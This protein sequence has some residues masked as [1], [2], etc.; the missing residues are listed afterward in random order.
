MDTLNTKFPNEMWMHVFSYSDGQSLK[1]VSL[2]SRRF[3]SLGMEELLH[4]LVW[5]SKKQAEQNLDF[6]EAAVDCRYI[7]TSLSMKFSRRIDP[8]PDIFNH[9]P[10][11]YNLGTLSLSDASCELP[12]PP[13]HFPL[14]Y[15]SFSDV[16][17]EPP[18]IGITDLSVRN[19]LGNFGEPLPIPE[20][21]EYLPHL[22]TL[23][24]DY[25]YIH[26]SEPILPQLTSFTLLPSSSSPDFMGTWM[27][28][29]LGHAKNLRHLT[30]GV[31][32]ALT[33][34]NTP[35]PVQAALPFL[36][37]F[38]GPAFVADGILDGAPALLALIIN[39]V[40]KK[41]EEALSI[42]ERV[43]DAATLR[44]IDLK[45][46][47][48][49]DEVL[50]AITHRLPACRSVKV[51]F[52]FLEPTEAF[53][54][55][56]GVE[57]LPLLE[58]L[59]TLHVHARG[60]RAAKVAQRNDEDDVQAIYGLTHAHVHPSARGH[61]LRARREVETRQPRPDAVAPPEEQCVEHL[62]AW[63]RYNENLRNVRFA[64]ERE[65]ERLYIGGR[66][67]VGTVS[68]FDPGSGR[69]E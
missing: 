57:H 54:F 60:H 26:P 36:E 14:S 27:N 59:H 52:R 66:W 20:L 25:T 22:R 11:F 35:P 10:W 67:I 18:E 21:F 12:H 1:A 48:W 32:R 64:L 31:P 24:T 4:T 28:N 41:T 68:G 47:E 40:F 15:P 30:I 3:R 2:T 38:T 46:V 56:L 62:A 8:G 58:Q 44:E 50:L 29:C 55:N 34:R 13:D 45:L 17:A 33:T 65:W 16:T 39:T 61:A 49:D 6:W 19:V 23:T 7:P 42:I 69:M 51:S 9:I 5:Q 43:N 63:T 53:L 37:T